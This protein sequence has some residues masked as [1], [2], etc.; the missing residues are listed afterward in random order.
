MTERLLSQ[1][2][3]SS[4]YKFALLIALTNI[5]AERGDDTSDDLEVALEDV[6]LS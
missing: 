3:F 5:A 1:G 4:T 2:Q 6:A